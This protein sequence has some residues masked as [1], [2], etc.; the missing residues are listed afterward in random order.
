MTNNR[1]MLDYASRNRTTL[2]YDMYVM[3][4]RSIQNGSQDSWTIT[5]KRIAALEAAATAE[6]PAAGARSAG[7]RRGGAAPATETPGLSQAPAAP[8]PG[9]VGGGRGNGGL[10]AALYTS[11][12]HDPTKRDPR[13]YILPSDQPDFPTAVKF[14]NTLMKSGVTI[15]KATAAFDVDGKHYPAGSLVINAAQA[16]RPE[17]LDMMEPQDHPDDFAYPGAPPTRPYDTTGW[18]LAYQMG[19]TFDRVYSNPTGP[20]EKIKTDLARAARRNPL[21]SRQTR[22]LP[23]FARVQRRPTPS[24]TVCS[25]PTSPSSG[26]SNPPPSKAKQLA[27]GALWIPYSAA[28]PRSARNCCQDPG[29][30]CLGGRLQT[31]RRIARAA[32]RPHRP[33]RHLRRLHDLRLDALAL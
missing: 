22:R 30:Q 18:T 3:G 26:S 11:V 1:A 13:G 15:E 10:P 20:F 33:G 16:Y 32:P 9:V 19:V 12:L 4:K 28:V 6:A 23:R 17:I 7:G 25:R 2:L 29:H 21:R 14:V 5:P 24:P 31:R 8:A 27:A